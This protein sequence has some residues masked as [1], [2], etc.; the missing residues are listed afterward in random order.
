MASLT[1]GSHGWSLGG[2]LLPPGVLAFC[3]LVTLKVFSS[4]GVSD[5]GYVADMHVFISGLRTS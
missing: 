3:S 1:C 4:L 5:L 2:L